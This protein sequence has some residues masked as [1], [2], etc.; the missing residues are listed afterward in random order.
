MIASLEKIFNST[1]A[2]TPFCQWGSGRNTTGRTTTTV[3][4]RKDDN[5]RASVG[6]LGY[7]A[8]IRATIQVTRGHGREKTLGVGKTAGQEALAVQ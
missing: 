6:N 2:D 4:E 8:S 7:P 1:I 5:Q 3:K